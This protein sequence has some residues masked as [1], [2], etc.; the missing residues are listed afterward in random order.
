MMPDTV[1]IQTSRKPIVV[2]ST[3]RH[4][5]AICCHGRWSLRT[6]LIRPR[7]CNPISRNTAFSSRNCTVRQ[8][9]FSAIRERADCNCGAR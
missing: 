7:N 3:A 8:L 6:L 5:H 1:N 9:P 4:G 2:A